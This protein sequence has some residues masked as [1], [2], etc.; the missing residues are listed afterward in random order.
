MSKSTGKIARRRT[1]VEWM[2]VKELGVEDDATIARRLG[3]S[4]GT[5]RAARARIGIRIPR[6]HIPWETVDWTRN[7]RQ[8]AAALGCSTSAVMR[9]RIARGIFREGTT[10]CRRAK[11]WEAEPLLG[12]VP[13][14]VLCELRG[15]ARPSVAA[16]R[17]RR[18]P[19]AATF[20]N[21]VLPSTHAMILALRREW[22]GFEVSTA[23]W[24]AV[25]ASTGCHEDA[26]RDARALVKKR[27]RART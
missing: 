10:D 5:V 6:R 18:V 24:L 27:R 9:Q 12:K 21:L 14:S 19:T 1:L 25:A 7:D 4:K 15:W 13:D 11:R 2:R 23:A 3:C 26:V 17:R 22:P 16:A 20:G 8:L